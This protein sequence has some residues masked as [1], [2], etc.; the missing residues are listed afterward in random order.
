M[1]KHDTIIQGIKAIHTEISAIK[2]VQKDMQDKHA[3]FIGQI[4]TN[5]E[6]IRTLKTH[7]D[8]IIRVLIGAG[9]IGTGGV[10]L[11]GLGYIAYKNL[12]G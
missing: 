4:A 1:T 6:S 5:T 3:E 2:V 8:M 11:G 12:G 7:S 10:F 9:G